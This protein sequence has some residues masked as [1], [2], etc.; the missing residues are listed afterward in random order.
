MKVSDM[1]PNKWLTGEDLQ[2]KAVPVEIDVVT[3][4]KMRLPGK[5]EEE[6]YVLHF[7]GKDKGL[8]LGKQ[9]CESI[10]LAT[11]C[12]DTDDW[13]GKKIVIFP[14]PM[15][16]AGRAVTAIRARKAV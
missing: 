16:V 7:K 9:L 3:R 11:G 12:E 13:R 5:P 1:F 2:G 10:V 8:R 4:E 6:A 15:T 14:V